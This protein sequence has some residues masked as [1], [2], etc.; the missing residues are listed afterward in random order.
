M[1]QKENENVNIKVDVRLLSDAVIELNISR[2]NVS[3]YPEDHPSVEN[4]LN[5]SFE[6]LQKIFQ[7]RPEITLAVAKDAL[8]IDDSYLDRKNTSYREFALYLNRRNIAFITFMKGI[9]KEELYKF[10]RIISEKITDAFPE[11]MQQLFHE[12]PLA[13]IKAGF[14][15]YGA[16]SF[17]ED[18]T[19]TG[20]L[21]APLWERYIYGLLKGDILTSDAPSEFKEVPPD[22]M[23]NFFNNIADSRINVETYDKV[24]A[25]YFKR[26]R[27]KGFLSGEIKKLLDFI[28][29]LSP[30]LKKHFLSSAARVFVKDI[31][32][33]CKE[34]GSPSKEEIVGLLHA[35]NEHH[36]AMP[37]ALKNLLD[38]LSTLPHDG[39]SLVSYKGNLL[40]DDIVL[41]RDI[42][43]LFN[44]NFTSFV[45]ESYRE[46]L[47]KLQEYNAS[48][49]AT[50]KYKEFEKEYSDDYIENDFHDIVLELLLSDTISGDD[51]GSFMNILQEQVDRL[52]WTGQYDGIRKALKVLALNS[53]N[54]RFPDMTEQ[55]LQYFHS[56]D[57]I[58][59]L[60]E[61]F[62][63]VG[64]QAREE[65]WLL[66][67]QYGEEI[68]NP[69]LDALVQEESP[70]VR[71][72]FLG[73]LT[74]LGDKVVP[75]AIKRLGDG[76]WFVKRN[77][78][79]L[80]SEINSE[81]A[82]PHIRP[83]SR[84]EN[85]KVSFEAMK[86]L[87]NAGDSYGTEAIRYFLRSEI[88]ENVER[89]INF[90]GS[91]KV[92][93]IVPDLLQ[94]LKKRVISGADLYNKMPIVKVLGEIGDP[95]SLKTL[96][97]IVS[98]K[99]ILFK[100]A[101]DR[102]KEEIYRSLKNYPPEDIREF[103]ETGLKSRND[104]VRR[105]SLR[106]SRIKGKSV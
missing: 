30:E 81:E 53:E 49:L 82:L 9:T 31:E 61:S 78:L 104:I 88:P 73:L 4:S 40:A 105:E 70:M 65:A 32:T 93:D 76:R 45:T 26:S 41:S 80:L 47:S 50:F 64:R 23:A 15:D 8:I 11:R 18:G 46:E 95:G 43:N 10:H 63:I 85:R 86:Y 97:D 91:F 101:L 17:E 68:I 24:V 29:D 48:G 14:I 98:G 21:N 106:L 27:E 16:F 35:M 79:Y 60:I 55:T 44:T 71:K 38:K 87:L 57:F 62:R 102:L 12:H 13:H 25:S 5:R 51:Y 67:E 99:S 42:V 52:I 58:S 56:G 2:R 100:N 54:N 28:N 1:G 74:Q 83:Y 3:I 7:L 103:I 94:L 34:P 77:M 75:E 69:M 84:H 59:K 36:A 19:E 20:S 22:I 89:A 72:F 92:R 39:F 96:K 6:L 66:S 90:A 33:A 37:E